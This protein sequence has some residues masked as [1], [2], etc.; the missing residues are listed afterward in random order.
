VNARKLIASALLAAVALA[1]AAAEPTRCPEGRVTVTAADSADIEDGCDGAAAAIAF[2]AA[3]GV[4]PRGSIEIS[5]V[6]VMPPVVADSP[7]VGCYVRS[8]G[9]IYVLAFERCRTL[10]M[11]HD[12]PV[13]RAVH[14]GLVAHEVAHRIVADH[15]APQRLGTIAHEYIAYVVM[16]QSMPADGR[17]RLLGQLP[18]GGFETGTEAEAGINLTIYLLDPVLFGTRA[19]RHYMAQRDGPE[20]LARVM[21]GKALASDE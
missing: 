9:R 5:F 4:E 6:D 10:R 7:S 12:I 3:Q 14:R 11:G 17:E 20:F 21:A 16:Y 13:D 18:G 8:E 2:F 1:A 19:Y 15:V